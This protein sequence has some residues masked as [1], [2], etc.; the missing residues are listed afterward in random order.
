MNKRK[1]TKSIVSFT[2]V[3]ALAF[4]TNP[5]LANEYSNSS[6][7]GVVIA[8]NTSGSAVEI[9][10]TGLLPVLSLSERITKTYLICEDITINNNVDEYDTI[11][12]K[13]LNYLDYT[14][15]NFYCSLNIY[16]DI[17]LQEKIYET[18]IS[19]YFLNQSNYQVNIPQLGREAGNVYITFQYPNKEVSDTIAVKYNAELTTGTLNEANISVVN[20]FNGSSNLI[21]MSL[22][23]LKVDDTI[24]V[25]TLSNDVYTLIASGKATWDS[26][27][28][29][30]LT[31][32]NSTSTL[33]ISN[34]SLGYAES[35]KLELQIE[36]AKI[37]TFGTGN[38]D[39]PEPKLNILNNLGKD[40][41]SVSNV[42]NN[43]VITVYA[44][45]NKTTK[46][47]STTISGSGQLSLTNVGNYNQIYVSLR[48]PNKLES[49]VIPVAVSEAN[50]TSLTYDKIDISNNSGVN[51]YI[52]LS[53]LMYTD[54]S[55]KST[56]V[57]MTVYGNATKTTTLYTGSVSYTYTQ[58]NK[59]YSVSMG[60]KLG[61]TNGTVYV[62]FK[63]PTKTESNVIPISYEAEKTSTNIE[64]S[65][66]SLETRYTGTSN[67]VYVTA[68]NLNQGDIVYVY[69][70]LANGT[71]TS[72]T[73]TTAG[74]T[75]IA[76]ASFTKP[77]DAETLG[78]TVKRVNQYESTVKVDL[79]IP[80]AETTTFGT[81]NSDFPEPVLVARDLTGS[82]RLEVSGVGTGTVVTVYTNSTK[83]TKLT[84][85]TINTSGNIS[86]S[87]IKSYTNLY[88]TFRAPNKFESEV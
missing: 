23:N 52:N 45:E 14:G 77:T 18:E 34:T 66:V 13:G 83:T 67:V 85:A 3:C 64:K 38:S 25:Y 65:D 47:Q 87:N 24:K 62:T 81:V 59:D 71:Y 30:N 56:T 54:E 2:L 37:T 33:Y 7:E 76:T 27:A 40:Y 75:G 10:K 22:V 41:L 48:V 72:V 17:N 5:I 39:I 1:N 36:D 53:N 79:A 88:V 74:S 32:P 44:D 11:N 43:T 82:D 60:N 12:F 55:D 46:L 15:E 29:I 73:N 80:V 8:N 70:K 19:S 50:Q 16:S 42:P 21:A 63:Y 61:Q 9:E 35:E 57:T 49:E 28:T 78:F 20:N 31:L 84:S 4:P 26:K 68:T 69:K 58:G 6:T 86:I 51:D